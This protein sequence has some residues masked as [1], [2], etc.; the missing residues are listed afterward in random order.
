MDF[1]RK[2]RRDIFAWA[3]FGTLLIGVDLLR[4]ALDGTLGP[5]HCWYLLWLVVLGGVLLTELYRY[6]QDIVCRESKTHGS[7]LI[8]IYL[9]IDLLLVKNWPGSHWGSLRQPIDI[10]FAA[11]VTVILLLVLLWTGFEVYRY[12]RR[13]EVF[14]AEAV[15]SF[16]TVLV[17]LLVAAFVIMLILLLSL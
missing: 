13:N 14:T 15:K 3:V 4:A 5:R 8:G 12:A 2:G 9:T 17:I 6:K 10:A 16:Y 11:T 7:F 1:A